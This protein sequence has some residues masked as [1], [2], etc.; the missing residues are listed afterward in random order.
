MDQTHRISFQVILDLC[1]DCTGLQTSALDARLSIIRNK[2]SRRLDTY[3]EAV[4]PQDLYVNAMV[5]QPLR[6]ARYDSPVR[7]SRV[8]QPCDVDPKTIISRSH[9]IAEGI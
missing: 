6:K 1:I 5:R 7:V 3:L 8:Q 9:G 2:V 4:P